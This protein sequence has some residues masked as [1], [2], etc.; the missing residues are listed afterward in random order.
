ML[1]GIGTAIHTYVHEELANQIALEKVTLLY[2]LLF[3]FGFFFLFTLLFTSRA[4]HLYLTDPDPG[5]IPVDFFELCN[6]LR[7]TS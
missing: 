2:L 4:P 7:N 3:C 1:L 5:L 6:R